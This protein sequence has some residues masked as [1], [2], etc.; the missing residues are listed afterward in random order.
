MIFKGP[1]QPKPLFDSITT[2]HHHHHSVSFSWILN[3][4]AGAFEGFLGTHGN[5]RHEV[6]SG[7]WVY[8]ESPSPTHMERPGTWATKGHAIIRLLGLSPLSRPKNHTRN[9]DTVLLAARGWACR[10]WELL[11]ALFLW[12]QDSYCCP[13]PHLGAP[14]SYSKQSTLLSPETGLSLQRCVW[15]RYSFPMPVVSPCWYSYAESHH[16]HLP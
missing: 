9:S 11:L 4:A 16:Q 6:G 8:G 5:P 2:H 15:G 13:A 14:G 3:K 12:L 1:F 7:E 10:S